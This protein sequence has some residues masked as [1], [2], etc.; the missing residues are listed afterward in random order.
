MNKK[1]TYLALVLSYFVCVTAKAVFNN[2]VTGIIT[3]AK[4]EEGCTFVFGLFSKCLDD[5]EKNCFNVLIKNC[6]GNIVANLTDSIEFVD[7][8]TKPF[9]TKIDLDLD[10]LVGSSN[11]DK[12]K[13]QN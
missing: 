13:H 1:I 2:E 5:L 7:G 11:G 3:L 6:D 4:K 8:G 12:R 10:N 9:F